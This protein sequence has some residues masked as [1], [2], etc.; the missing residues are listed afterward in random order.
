MNGMNINQM[1][2]TSINNTNPMLQIPPMKQ[3]NNLNNNQMNMNVI[4][5]INQM[6]S[7][8]HV[9]TNPISNQIYPS[10]QHIPSNFSNEVKTEKEDKRGR[11]RAQVTGD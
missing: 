7:I 4:T 9:D 10:S 8:S 3:M 6:N 1:N 11:K 2:T 5:Q